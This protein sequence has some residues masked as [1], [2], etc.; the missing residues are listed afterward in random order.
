MMDKKLVWKYFYFF[1]I[2][3]KYLVYLRKPD[4]KSVKII[5][6]NLRNVTKAFRVQNTT[7]AQS[8]SLL[9]NSEMFQNTTCAQIVYLFHNSEMFENEIKNRQKLVTV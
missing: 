1:R 2:P 4:N 3:L 6:S 5:D 9:Q 8:V 7:C